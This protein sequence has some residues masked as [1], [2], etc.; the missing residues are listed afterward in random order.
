M[1]S[2]IKTTKEAGKPKEIEEF[3]ENMRLSEYY[4]NFEPKNT[5]DVQ[6]WVEYYVKKMQN[7]Y[8]TTPIKIG[9]LK[10]KSRLEEFNREIVKKWLKENNINNAIE[11][12][13]YIKKTYKKIHKNT[14]IREKRKEAKNK[15]KE[16]NKFSHLDMIE[17][18][19]L[20]AE[21]DMQLK[22]FSKIAQ[23][24]ASR[25]SEML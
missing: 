10:I 20:K 8:N 19:A 15:L 17:I 22:I 13:E 4:D 2:N 14:N 18:I 24:R 1:K 21:T 25:L 12:E 11:L 9:V 5:N 6:E 7:I 23:A 16:K 3:E